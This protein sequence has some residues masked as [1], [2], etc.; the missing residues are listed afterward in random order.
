MSIEFGGPVNE[1]SRN[2]VNTTPL[3]AIGE[4][5]YSPEAI[6]G[7][8]DLSSFAG[9]TLAS[10]VS[11]SLNI[12]SMALDLG[13]GANGAEKAIGPASIAMACSPAEGGSI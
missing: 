12:A 2:V 9:R 5:I 3:T 7:F 10:V 6:Q 4:A 1:V 13:A 11:N 8:I